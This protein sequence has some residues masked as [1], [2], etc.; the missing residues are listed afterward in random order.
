MKYLDYTGLSHF[1]EQLYSLLG[2]KADKTYV[3]NKVKT[4]VPAGAKFT[5]TNTITSINGK[6]GAIAKSDIVALGIP[7]QDTVYTLPATLPY[8]ML[9]GTPTIPNVNGK[10]D[11]TY[12][13]GLIGDISSVLDA[14][15]GEVI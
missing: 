13:D 4:D 6:T 12:V 15:N 1:I 9:T 7:A 10:A 14:I 3:D 5:D 8:S 2:T 11:I